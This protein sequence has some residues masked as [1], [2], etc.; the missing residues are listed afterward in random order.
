[1][2][3]LGHD[4]IRLHYGDKPKPS[5]EIR[6]ENRGVTSRLI[7]TARYSRPQGDSQLKGC[8]K[9]ERSEAK[10]HAGCRVVWEG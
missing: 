4:R 1:M 3:E 7:G 10:P 2:P 6:R 8:P 9:G 5:G